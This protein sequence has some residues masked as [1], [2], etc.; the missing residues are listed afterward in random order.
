MSDMFGLFHALTLVADVSSHEGR[1]I[2]SLL[3]P[4]GVLARVGAVS[5]L[6]DRG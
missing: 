3:A 2:E 4:L 5:A 6:E 1:S